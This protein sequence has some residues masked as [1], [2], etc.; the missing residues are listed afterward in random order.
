MILE[1]TGGRRARIWGG[2][3]FDGGGGG[4]GFSF[5]GFA[6][7]GFGFGLGGFGTRRFA[8]FLELVGGLVEGAIEGGLA[9]PDGFQPGI[10][11]PL[12][13]LGFPAGFHFFEAGAFEQSNGHLLDEGSLGEVAGL[14]LGIQFIA[15]LLEALVGAE[16]DFAGAEAVL[17]SV[18][19]G[20]SLAFGSD[21]SGG[22]L[23]VLAV[24]LNLLFG[25]HCVFT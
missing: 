6:F 18:L 7:G 25:C 24:G 15:K 2:I 23:R 21:G 4:D 10:E 11:V 3:G 22:V 12:V 13:D 5:G 16:Q 14:V 19:S 9:A 1:L 8:E 20:G 17:E